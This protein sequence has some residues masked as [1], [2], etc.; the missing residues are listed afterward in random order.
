MDEITEFRNRCQ[1]LLQNP[2]LTSADKLERDLRKYAR[3][4][5]ALN[6]VVR[7]IEGHR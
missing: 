2:T 4:A 3:G 5:S 1:Q 6:V 7:L